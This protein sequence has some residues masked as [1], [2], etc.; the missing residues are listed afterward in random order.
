MGLLG[1]GADP[2]AARRAF[3]TFRNSTNYDFLL[4]QG[5][6]AV[7]TANAPSFNSGATA[8]A[9][10][11][12]GQ[13]M[14]GNALAG[15]EGLLAGQ[16]Q[17]GTQA[18]LGLGSIGV[19]ASG[20]FSSANNNA[21]G[22]AGSAGIYGANTQGSALQGLSSLLGANRSTSSFAPLQDTFTAQTSGSGID[23]G[24]GSAVAGLF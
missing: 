21:A 9:L 5:T 12:Y 22:I 24:P 18:A 4:N 15:Y 3:D 13:G 1:L 17:L 8:K 16:Q 7:K 20:Q 14:A 23:I 10:L 19:G 6:Q 11:N 2:A